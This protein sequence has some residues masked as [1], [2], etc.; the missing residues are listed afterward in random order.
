M[1]YAVMAERIQNMWRGE[2]ARRW[3]RMIRRAKE[4]EKINMIQRQWRRYRAAKRA[5]EKKAE[6]QAVRN[7][8]HDMQKAYM[9][10]G[11]E[12]ILHYCYYFQKDQNDIGDAKYNNVNSVFLLPDHKSDS[13]LDN[14]ESFLVNCE[15]QL[16][17]IEFT[18]KQKGIIF[19]IN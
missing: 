10:G 3:L 7:Y 12:S 4:L 1:I 16:V 2:L 19:S 9:Q 6:V 5:L 18:F 17:K 15:S 13:F 8:I 14:C 11:L